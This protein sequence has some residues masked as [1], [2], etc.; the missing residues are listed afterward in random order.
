MAGCL[1]DIYNPY[2]LANLIINHCNSS[3]T[4]S[5]LIQI[6]RNSYITYK[7]LIPIILNFILLA[8]ALPYSPPYQYIGCISTSSAPPFT[9][10]FLQAPFTASQCLQSCARAATLI[11]IG[12]GSCLC[13][14]GGA[15]ASFELIDEQRCNVLC[16]EGDE[17]SGQCGG[18]GVLSLYQ[19]A[20][21]DGGEC[22]GKNGTVPPVVQK[23]SPCTSCNGTGTPVPVPAPTQTQ[24]QQVTG[25]ICPPEGCTTVVPLPIATPSGNSTGK[26]CPSG[27]CTANKQAGSQSGSSQSPSGSSG[28]GSNEAPRL[29]SDSPRLYAPSIL[30]AIAA[31]IFGLGLL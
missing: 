14:A 28:K 4:V 13:D 12:A 20:G 19:L 31:V 25:V 6:Q 5:P 9:P 2:C 15:S 27:G 7:M 24:Q 1:Q 16:V 23:P 10:A 26:T 17:S 30:S 22:L 3:H 29:A 8:T 18:D 11:A 21:C